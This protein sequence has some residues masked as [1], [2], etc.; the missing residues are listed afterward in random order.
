MTK[1]TLQISKDPSF[2][3]HKAKFFNYDLLKTEIMKEYSNIEIIFTNNSERMFQI[4]SFGEASL[5]FDDFDA[6]LY[7]E[8]EIFN[9][10]HNNLDLSDE[11]YYEKILEKWKT[12]NIEYQLLSKITTTL[13]F[14]QSPMPQRLISLKKGDTFLFKEEVVFMAHR[15]MWELGLE[16][17]ANHHN[18]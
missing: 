17:L 6:I 11:K 13:D 10:C 18:I 12:H 9:F 4:F 1:I 7:V 2:I 3:G 15:K 14:T 5:K 8:R 16:K